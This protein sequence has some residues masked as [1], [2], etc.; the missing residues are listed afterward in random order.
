MRVQGLIGFLESKKAGVCEEKRRP[1]KSVI[2]LKSSAKLIS[3]QKGSRGMSHVKK[4]RR[5][6]GK[7]KK[8]RTLEGENKE[9]KINKKRMVTLDKGSPGPANHNQARGTGKGRTTDA[10]WDILDNSRKQEKT[11]MGKGGERT[12][13]GRKV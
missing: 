3:S 11:S 13:W 5:E 2:R 9:E 1:R 7:L 4:V 10:L 12:D 6:K 8:K